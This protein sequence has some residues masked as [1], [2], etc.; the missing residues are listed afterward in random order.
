MNPFEFLE[1]ALGLG[2]DESVARGP[3][4]LK[5]G[6]VKKA[7]EKSR[8]RPRPRKVREIRIANIT[9]PIDREPL[10]LLVVGATGTGKSQVIE[11]MVAQI[12]DRGDVAI[13]A[14]AGGEMLSRWWRDG[15]IIANP[16]DARSVTWSPFAEIDDE[17]DA[18]RLAAALIP[19]GE[20][21]QEREWVRYA[22]R[23]L[24]E[25]FRRL[26]ERGAATTGRLVNICADPENVKLLLADTPLGGFVEGGAAQ[27]RDS[28]LNI[29]ALR[30]ST[31]LR[32]LDS[33]AGTNA[34]SV[35]KWVRGVDEREPAWLWLSYRLK[36]IKSVSV[37]YSTL[38]AEAITEILE[39][40]PVDQRHLE[41][42]RRV[43]LIIDELPVLGRVQALSQALTLGR[44]FGLRAV[45]GLQSI[46]QLQTEYGYLGATTMLSCL[47]TYIALR[48]GDPETAEVMSRALGEAQLRRKIDERTQINI[49]RAVLAGELQYLDDLRGFLRMAGMPGVAEIEIPI[50]AASRAWVPRFEPRNNNTG[51]APAGAP[52]AAAAQ[53][54]P[55]ATGSGQSQRQGGGVADG[56]GND[57]DGGD[58]DAYGAS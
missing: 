15:D 14:D 30:A 10:H 1:R 16:L 45:F 35:R 36:D 32:V 11:S 29:I 3:E 2:P 34:W 12:R 33:G 40:E 48:C 31:A 51:G 24:A 44:K 13:V 5:G 53:N 22:Q 39:L 28:V 17:E 23:C 9:Y 8:R 47:S 38:I 50:V 54:P 56:G 26:R 57:G 37:I 18:D 41:H 19:D 7:V 4:R 46:S 21:P 43:W 27:M 20:S 25:I 58:S 6:K 52:P 49:E 42:G 55:Q